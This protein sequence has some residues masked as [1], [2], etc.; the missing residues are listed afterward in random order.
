MGLSQL[1]HSMALVDSD[2]GF[3]EILNLAV[4]EEDYVLDDDVANRTA[5]NTLKHLKHCRK[6]L[7]SVG[8]L[9]ENQNFSGESSRARVVAPFSRSELMV[10]RLLGT[11]G[12]SS[13][14]EVE[15][16]HQDS[17]LSQGVTQVEEASRQFLTDHALRKR[18]KQSRR[19]KNM[20]QS[21]VIPR[22]AIK[23]LRHSLVLNPER[24]ERAA[25]DLVLEGQLLLAMDHP[26][27]ISIRGWSY[28]GPDA[29]RSGKY[30]DYFL[31]L[32]RL[33]ETADLRIEDW[34]NSLRKYRSRHAAFPWS[35]AKYAAK[36]RRLVRERV[37]MAIGV[38]SAIEYMHDRRIIN[39]DIK[40]SN[41]GFDVHGD[42]KV[43][44][45]G[46]SRLLPDESEMDENGRYALS[47]VGTKA[48]M[49]LEVR[50]KQCYNLSVDVYSF[51][52]VLWEIMALATPSEHMLKNRTD[53]E[54]QEFQSNED[55]LPICACWPPAIQNL[56]RQCLSHNDRPFIGDALKVLKQVLASLSRDD[57]TCSEPTQT[58]RR[59]TFRVDLSM[60]Q[61][62]SV[63]SKTSNTS[64]LFENDGVCSQHVP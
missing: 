3:F 62:E 50:S 56:I 16:F 40:T 11:G 30:S 35:K 10:G 38:A 27:I 23:H 54:E 15:E 21:D 53:L 61:N 18:D 51:G 32:D 55:W 57:P 43:F 22:Y 4:K 8:L 45:F 33:A 44:D 6:H 48:Y 52:V 13:V 59:S 19:R 1:F 63:E 9:R 26:N 5:D 42:V 60:E 37:E 58:K 41:I 64:S 39:R 28:E 31:I 49:P 20:F 2:F 7:S 47:R 12:F 24:F 46:L 29:Y 17:V 14:Y 34:R 25:I 36:M